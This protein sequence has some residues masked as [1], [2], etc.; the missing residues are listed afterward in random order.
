ML[1]SQTASIISHTGNMLLSHRRQFEGIHM[2]TIH[3]CVNCVQIYNN[4]LYSNQKKRRVFLGCFVP[5]A[6]QDTILMLYSNSRLL[7]LI[8][9]K[10]ARL[11]KSS[12]KQF[13]RGATPTIHWC[14]RPFQGFVLLGS[15]QPISPTFWCCSGWQHNPPEYQPL[16][17]FICHQQ[18]CWKCTLYL[19]LA[20]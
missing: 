5:N 2:N 14:M 12:A 1:I 4:V 13:F 15:H 20:R 7:F 6:A 11:Y 19:H 8:T 10:Y 18:T 9:S 17:P 16:L 3:R